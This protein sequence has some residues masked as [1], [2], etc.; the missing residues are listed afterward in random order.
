VLAVSAC[1]AWI[2]SSRFAVPVENVRSTFGRV[3][4]GGHADLVA[5]GSGWSSNHQDALA[6]AHRVVKASE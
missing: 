3:D 2:F 6:S 5:F 1:S 4:D